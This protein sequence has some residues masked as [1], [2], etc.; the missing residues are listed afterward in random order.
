MFITLDNGSNDFTKIPTKKGITMSNPFFEEFNTPFNAIPFDKIQNKHFLEALEMAIKEHK[1]EV[2]EF[3]NSDDDSF[4]TYE[5]Y[6]Q[7]GGALEKVAL[8]FFNLNS[9][10]TND[11]MTEIANEFSPK[12]TAHNNDIRLDSEVFR[13]IK[14]LYEKKNDLDLNRE[15]LTLLEND[16]KSFVRNGALLNDSDKDKLRKIDE[17]LS[18]LSLKFSNN[19][20][21]ET[22]NFQLVITNEDDLKGL[23]DGVKEAAKSLAKENGKEDA[24]IFTLD[25]PS[26]FPFLTYA[27][28]R[29]LR[30]E[31]HLASAK[32]CDND[33]EFNNAENCQKI[34]TLRHE[35]ANL[36]GYSTHAEF[37]FEERMAQNKENVYGLLGELKEKALPAAKAHVD[38]LKK[39]AQ[40]KDNLNDLMPWDYHFYNEKLKKEKFNIDD[41]MLK[42][43]FQLEKVIDGVFEVATKL[44]G[45]KFTIR[46]DIPKYHQD[47][48]TYE[49]TDEEDNHVAVFYGDYF[50]RKGKRSGAW[51][52]EFRSQYIDNG[53]D[54]RPLISNVC[55]FTKPTESKPS[56]LTFNEVLTLFHEFGH[57]L[58]GILSKC[59]YKATSGTRVFWDFVELPSQ[60]LENWAYEKECLD[61]FARHYET[62]EKIP[63]ELIQKIKDS[64]NFGE[65]YS[66]IRQLNFAFIDLAWHTSDPREIKDIK[67]FEEQ[68][69][70]DISLFPKIENSTTSTA[71][72][73][74]FAGG[75]SAGYYSYKWA[76]V[77]DA[78]AFEAF[79][80]KGI[81][82]REIAD[83]FRENIL[84]RGGSEHPMT[85]YKRFRGSEP[86]VDPLLKRGGLV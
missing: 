50:P 36:L 72:S 51:M 34:A 65:G 58:H 45:L 26:L 21:K 14:D 10:N 12:L 81:F 11:E 80:E 7:G 56:L 28:N 9:A 78:D 44:Y 76:E 79:K 49:I 24:W 27:Q 32:R 43:Y 46:N 60:V 17:E 8:T 47:V 62:D 67:E 54:I 31:I 82:N 69:L 64:S 83:R 48:I 4:A 68:V 22:Q 59:H 23:P 19:V 30:K 41:E 73:H 53:T 2:E 52:T 18:T 15:Q 16:Y 13:K 5:K 63:E 77:L 42:P 37:V 74:I 55:N 1:K 75:Y 71:F 6:V 33:N 38:K 85:L 86:S 84:E 29:E 39:Y 3:K 35:R 66:T 40:D 57:G 20:L 70:K 25:Y 61:L